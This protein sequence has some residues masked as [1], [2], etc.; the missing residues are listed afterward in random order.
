MQPGVG[1]PV[2][3]GGDRKEM[4]EDISSPGV[5][6]VKPKLRVVKTS[7]L[8]NMQGVLRNV[9]NHVVINKV[10]GRVVDEGFGLLSLILVFSN[11]VG[12]QASGTSKGS[13]HQFW[14]YLDEVN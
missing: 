9:G 14:Y 11:I 10:G 6:I 3:M 1:T 2:M 5:I 13:T 12:T 7:A 8:K 4:G